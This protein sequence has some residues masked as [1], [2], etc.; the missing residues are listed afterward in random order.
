VVEK[1]VKIF[2]EDDAMDIIL[3]V[4][5]DTLNVIVG[6]VG[7]FTLAGMALFWPFFSP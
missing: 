5:G 3:S 2:L 4:I 7:F 1:S 6:S